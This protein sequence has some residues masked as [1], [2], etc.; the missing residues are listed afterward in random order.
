M[1]LR[2]ALFQRFGQFCVNISETSV[3]HDYN[4]VAF[5]DCFTH[6]LN[7]T[8][9]GFQVPGIATHAAQVCYQAVQVELFIAGYIFD[10][11]GSYQL[12]FIINTGVGV[13]G[14]ILTALLRPTR[15]EA[16]L[17]RVRT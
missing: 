11:T 6:L 2:K 16:A 9:N 15:P 1:R 13:L 8:L 3:G 7:D 14:L 17:G 4:Q 10:T 12:A 5:P